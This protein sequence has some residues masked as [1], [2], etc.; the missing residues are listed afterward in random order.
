M[1][2]RQNE[3]ESCGGHRRKRNE[4]RHLCLR[5]NRTESDLRHTM[6]VTGCRLAARRFGREQT[7]MRQCRRS[8]ERCR[9][10][11]KGTVGN[12]ACERRCGCASAAEEI[13]SEWESTTASGRS[14]GCGC[15]SVERREERTERN[16]ARNG[17]GCTY[18]CGGSG[19]GSCGCGQGVVCAFA[20]FTRRV[21]NGART[22][23][24]GG[25][26][27]CGGS[28]SC[29]C[30]GDQSSSCGCRRR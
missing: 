26:C 7:L 30:G 24:F 22:M 11:M 20:D 14:G 29:G 28:S 10:F 13:R 5:L 2:R 3:A 1:Q 17:C 16:A 8:G 15:A 6:K 23:L 12:M 9:R 18:G 27:G 21:A 25:S 4:L 19:R